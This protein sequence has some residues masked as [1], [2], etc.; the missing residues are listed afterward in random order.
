MAH[1]LG[2]ILVVVLVLLAAAVSG[3]TLRKPSLVRSGSLLRAKVEVGDSASVADGKS[4][5]VKTTAGEVIVANLKGKFYA[6]NAK[7]PHL[8][9]SMKIGKV[10]DGA[11]GP[12]ITCNFHDACFSLRNGK[13]S[14]WAQN[15]GMVDKM[16]PSGPENSPAIVYPCSVEKGKVVLTL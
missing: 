12:T 15:V 16:K 13:C 2:S 7:C 3:F 5:V 6:V 10:A 8:G 11:S 1:S 9:K 14:K 4:I